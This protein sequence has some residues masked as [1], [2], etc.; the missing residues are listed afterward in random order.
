MKY[1][2]LISITI[3]AQN[4]KPSYG[5]TCNNCGWCCITE[6]CN[7]GK[8]LGA[9]EL[10]CKFLTS[11]GKVHKCSLAVD[12]SVYKALSMG[13]GCDAKTQTEVIQEYT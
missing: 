10:P 3:K 2:D 7:V 5:D 8:G 11:T 9:K 6:V 12:E 13:V 4:N 1:S